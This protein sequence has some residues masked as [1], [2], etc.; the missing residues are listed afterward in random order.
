[1][2]AVYLF[3]C[4]RCP[5]PGFPCG[6]IIITNFWG[7]VKRFLDGFLPGLQGQ[8]ACCIAASAR[9]L[10]PTHWVSLIALGPQLYLKESP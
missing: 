1:M 7:Y 8:T 6:L 2:H 10:H 9:L 3:Y 4:V 5:S